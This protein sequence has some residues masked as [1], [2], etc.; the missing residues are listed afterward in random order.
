MKDGSPKVIFWRCEIYSVVCE[1]LNTC[2]RANLLA[3]VHDGGK[4]GLRRE[5]YGNV[6]KQSRRSPDH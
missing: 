6:R 1:R 4:N 2:P 3:A 5:N